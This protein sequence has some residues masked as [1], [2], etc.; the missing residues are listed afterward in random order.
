M[1]RLFIV[2]A[3]NNSR[4]H[5]SQISTSIH[6]IAFIQKCFNMTSLTG[7]EGMFHTMHISIIRGLIRLLQ[8]SS[9]PFN[10]SASYILYV[11]LPLLHVLLLLLVDSRLVMS[12]KRKVLLVLT[13]TNL[14]YWYPIL[15]LNNVFFQ[16]SF[17]LLVVQ[18]YRCRILKTCGESV[19]SIPHII[20]LFDF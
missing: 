6:T 1:T 8:T 10:Y 11:V 9:P 16:E 20:G 17:T 3:Q 19:S 12:H 18:L 15:F 14:V 4:E 2:S 13:I 7:H 5:N